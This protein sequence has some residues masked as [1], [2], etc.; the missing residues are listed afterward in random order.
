MES[1]TGSEDVFKDLYP[2]S[3]GL[4]INNDLSYFAAGDSFTITSYNDDIAFYKSMY[5]STDYIDM[6]ELD[7]DDDIIKNVKV[8]TT[9]STV[10][11]KIHTGRTI[12]VTRAGSDG[13]ETITDYTGSIHT[14]D[15][16]SISG[17]ENSFKVSVVG[18]VN[19]DGLADL[20][21]VT[22]LYKHVRAID[23]PNESNNL[24]EADYMLIAGNVN[25][26][27]VTDF[28]D[29]TRLYKHARAL[30]SPDESEWLLGYIFRNIKLFK[31]VR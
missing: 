5:A 4:R 10:V 17:L 28:S 11:G 31:E 20:S 19:C 24:I 7:V 29:V 21:D 9:I 1:T 16:I 15:L 27:S 18:D 25:G 30:D 26:D 8:G 2:N 22:R 12:T 13:Y 3:I 6:S 23:S 14:G